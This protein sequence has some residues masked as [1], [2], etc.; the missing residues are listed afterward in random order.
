MVCGASLSRMFLV[1]TIDNGI[2]VLGSAPRHAT[3]LYALDCGSLWC[4]KL[5]HKT[6]GLELFSVC[7]IWVCGVYLLRREPFH[8]FHGV[9]LF[10][11]KDLRILETRTSY[12]GAIVFVVIPS[13]DSRLQFFARCCLV[14]ER[15]FNQMIS[16]PINLLCSRTR[17][18]Y[19]EKCS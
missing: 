14:A 13:N 7:Y 11:V 2:C 5:W 12:K 1:C 9:V 6:V 8:P 17:I 18:T 15:R 10:S 4:C 19:Y 3:R 16:S